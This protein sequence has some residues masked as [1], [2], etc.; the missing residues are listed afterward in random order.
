MEENISDH[1]SIEDVN[2]TDTGLENECPEIYAAN[3]I[4]L[5][6]TV[7]EPARVIV[8]PL[9][10]DSWYRSPAV[11]RSVGGE[12]KSAHL[13]GRAADVVPN[14][15]VFA[16][17]KKIVAN[18]VMVPYD[19]I[20]HEKRHSEWIHIQIAKDGDRPLGLALLGRPDDTGKIKYTRYGE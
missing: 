5:A 7:L 8:G 9:L 12:A 4:K 20:I 11:N 14:G 15:D 17:F 6:E 2:H 13:E 1:F 18:H 10:V 3:V 16:A 19:R